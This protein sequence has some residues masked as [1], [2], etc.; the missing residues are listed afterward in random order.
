MTARTNRATLGISKIT[1]CPGA[2]ICSAGGTTRTTQQP[3]ITS[4]CIILPNDIVYY[5]PDVTLAQQGNQVWSYCNNLV[6]T[7]TINTATGDKVTSTYT[8][9]PEEASEVITV[10]ED[11]DTEAI[12][13]NAGL[14]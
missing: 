9:T 3:L 1:F 14:E 8:F 7:S 10:A 2:I 6:I 13:F 5:G 12:N 11:K 4:P